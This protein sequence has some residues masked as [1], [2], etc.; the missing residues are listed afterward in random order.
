MRKQI[1][2]RLFI[3][4]LMIVLPFIILIRGSVYLHE[5][6]FF[7][8]LPAIIGGFFLT[9]V[10]LLFY[11]IFILGTPAQSLKRRF[12][13]VLI[14]LLSYGGYAL[15][16]ISGKNVKSTEI[17]REYT[18][19]HPILRLG[20]TTILLVDK[21]LVVTDANRTPEDYRR[22]GLDDKSQSLHYRQKDGYTHAIDIRTNGRSG[23]RNFLLKIYFRAM[24]FNVMRHGGTGDHLHISLLSH[25]RPHA[26]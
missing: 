25:D 10:L 23:I 1:I 17:A 18:S 4:G 19:L 7:H 12:Q 15:L 14:L 11:L 16:Y 8:P 3:I 21:N 20:V 13:L 2:G 5:K 24:G 22:M 6:Y 9:A 26:F